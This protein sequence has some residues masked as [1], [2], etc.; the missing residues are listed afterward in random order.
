MKLKRQIYA[1]L[2]VSAL[3]MPG[4]VQA[5]DRAVQGVMG[6]MRMMQEQSGANADPN[7]KAIMDGVRRAMESSGRDQRG[8]R[9]HSKAGK[10]GHGAPQGG[11]R[12]GST[13]KHGQPQGQRSGGQPQG[14]RSGGQPQGQRPGGQPQ[15]QRP[16]GQPQGQRPGGQ[17]YGNRD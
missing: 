10:G 8:D 16:G 5:D 6:V 1:I 13:E 17:S 3:F 11:Q 2:S 12:Y 4:A 7:S 14:Q 9:G 15:G